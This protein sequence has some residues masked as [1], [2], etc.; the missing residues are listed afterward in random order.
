MTAMTSADQDKDTAEILRIMRAY[1]AAMVEARTDDLA[2]LLDDDFSLVHLSGYVQPRDEW[3]GV[4]RS[5]QFDYHGIDIEEKALSVEVAGSRAVLT[6]R[7]IFHATI[8][9]MK[10]PWRLQFTVQ[11]EEQDGG[12]TI[13]HARYVT[14]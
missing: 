9:G 8:N 2:E 1:H 3:F 11:Y 13:T 14:F 5:G 12:W 4:I 6:G 7:G 10:S